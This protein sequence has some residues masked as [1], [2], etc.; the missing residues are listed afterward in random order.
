MYNVSTENAENCLS[1]VDEF[2]D[3]VTVDNSNPGLLLKKQEAEKALDHLEM[4]FKTGA[5]E[6]EDDGSD[7]AAEC[8]PGAQ[9]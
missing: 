6:D 2:M 5:D 8:G 7:C 1:M 9:Q 3:A 4:L